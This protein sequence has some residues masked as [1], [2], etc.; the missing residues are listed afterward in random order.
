MGGLIK[1][2]ESICFG[3]IYVCGASFVICAALVFGN[4]IIN[5]ALR[6]VPGFQR[7]FNKLVDYAD[8]EWD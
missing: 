1:D 5:M 3:I 8:R 4:I 6:L 7:W 2:M